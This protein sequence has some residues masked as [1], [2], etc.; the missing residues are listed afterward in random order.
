MNCVLIKYYLIRAKEFRILL[1]FPR[2]SYLGETS[3]SGIVA[4]MSR[5][6]KRNIQTENKPRWSMLNIKPN[7][8][9]CISQQALSDH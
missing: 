6:L 2:V 7:L 4:L 8:G 1:P 3:I 9:R 5:S